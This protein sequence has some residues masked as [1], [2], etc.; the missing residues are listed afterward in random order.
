M[1]SEIKVIPVKASRYHRKLRQFPS[2]HLVNQF[3]VQLRLGLVLS[4]V[5]GLELEHSI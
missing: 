3:K 1:I 5:G 2:Q 4:A